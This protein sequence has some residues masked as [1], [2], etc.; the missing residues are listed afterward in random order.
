MFFRKLMH[1]KPAYDRYV[2]HTSIVAVHSVIHKKGNLD[3]LRIGSK[4]KVAAIRASTAISP[5][6]CIILRLKGQQQPHTTHHHIA[7]Y[8]TAANTFV[9]NK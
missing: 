2:V 3:R 6:H 5:L 9:L 4:Y 8:Q 7:L 1:T